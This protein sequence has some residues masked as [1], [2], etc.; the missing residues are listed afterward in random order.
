MNIDPKIECG[1]DCHRLGVPYMRTSLPPQPCCTCDL[2]VPWIKKTVEEFEK[3]YPNVTDD[4]SEEEKEFIKIL[5]KVPEISPETRAIHELFKHIES[6]TKKSHERHALQTEENQ[7]VSKRLD[8]L[9]EQSKERAHLINYKSYLA[10]SDKIEDLESRIK[11]CERFQD[12]THEQY[13]FV[14]KKKPHTCPA[15]NGNV[16]K[17]YKITSDLSTQ[18]YCISCEGKGIVWG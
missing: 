3:E 13:K 9:E 2:I 7:K 11:E 10:L 8:E 16:T 1:C 12:I 17:I 15:C 4:I 6:L 18:E 14:I 5:S